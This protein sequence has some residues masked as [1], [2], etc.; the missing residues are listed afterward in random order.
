MTYLLDINLLVALFDSQHVNHE[1]AHDWFAR[2]AVDSWATCPTTE[3]GFLRVISNPAYPTVTA[4]PTEVMNHL[5][6][7]CSNIG[8]VFW[9]DDLSLLEV[10]DNT[11][12]KRLMGHGQITDFYLTALAHHKEGRLA[13]FDGS[14]GRS[15]E[16]IVLAQS[17]EIVV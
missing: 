11:V 8:H 5:A 16:G 7:F 14:L 6:K 15:L 10:L 1:A 13:S 17:L 9:S 12:K 2:K 3:N 4:T